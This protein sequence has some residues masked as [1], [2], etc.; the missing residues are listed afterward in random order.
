MASRVLVMYATT[1]GQSGKIAGEI[2]A[3]MRAAGA[4]V[5]LGNVDEA[6]T[7]DPRD[8]STVVLVAPVHAGQFPSAMRQWARQY[9]AALASRPSA[10]VAVCLAVVNRTPKVDQDLRTMLDRFYKVTGWQPKETK[11]V[12]GALKYTKYNWF[13]RWMMKRI[14]GKAGGDVDTSRDFEY[15]DWEDL[16]DFALRFLGGSSEQS[17]TNKTEQ[18]LHS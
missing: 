1:H 2:A 7:S 11:V 3:S 6:W 13:T 18:L 12:A 15:T 17:A 4:T 5:S 9:H 8:Y 10:F 14:V 16:R